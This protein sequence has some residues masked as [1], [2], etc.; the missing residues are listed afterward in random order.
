MHFVCTHFTTS[1]PS[2]TSGHLLLI[3]SLLFLKPVMVQNWNVTGYNQ[4]QHKCC[5]VP[6]VR[7]PFPLE[8]RYIAC[9]FNTMQP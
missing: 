9:F 8:L 7:A 3:V 4:L 1:T 5:Y 2:H 6:P